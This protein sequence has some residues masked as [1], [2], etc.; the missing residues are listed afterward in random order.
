MFFL[1][2]GFCI[3]F[4]DK[5]KIKLKFITLDFKVIPLGH[6]LCFFVPLKCLCFFPKLLGEPLIIIFNILL[7]YLHLQHL[8]MWTWLQEDDRAVSSI[9]S[10]FNLLKL[11]F[12][13]IGKYFSYMNHVMRKPVYAICEQQG[14]RSACTN[15]KILATHQLSRLV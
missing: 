12:S 8:L 6:Y 15:F 11:M 9:P 7:F 3:K 13:S 14:R 10:F 4:T 2:H 5:T 1:S